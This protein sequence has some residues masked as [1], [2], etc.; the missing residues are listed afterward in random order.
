M[1][2]A[3]ALRLSAGAEGRIVRSA[4]PEDFEMPLDGFSTWITPTER[5]FVRSHFYRPEL[6]LE[7]W[8]LKAGKLA[9]DMAALRQFPRAELVGVLECAG[10]GRGLFKPGMPGVPWRYGAVG[11]ARWTGVRMAD[12]LRRAGFPSSV[13]HIL[14][15]GADEGIGSAPDFA[16][17]IP[18]EKAMHADTLLAYE[19]NGAPLPPEHGFPLRVVAPG[20]AG[21]SWVKWLVEIRGL[22]AEYD[23][24]FMKTAY[25]RPVK[26]VAPGTA[27][28]PA[29]MEPVTELGVKSVIASP[30]EGASVGPGQVTIRGAAWSGEAPVAR[31]EVSTDGGRTWTAAELSPD[32]APYAWRL[33]QASWTPPAK[34][35][36]ALMARATDTRGRTQPMEPAW[37]PSGYLFNAVHR[38]N[39]EAAAPFPESVKNS[40]VGCHGEDIIAGQRLTRAQW[41]REVEKM[42][43]WGAPVAP[44]DKAAIIQFLSENYKP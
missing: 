35:P 11:N 44:E 32:Q 29:E 42:A 13:K 6:K 23:G 3:P 25:R 30:V 40:C 24:F 8:R 33:W 5:F 26:P 7:E 37:N 27:V 22:E 19:M 2:A 17:S 16:R 18:I 38:V 12:V 34:G 14:C 39:V 36:H 31:V 1:A 4:N 21:D 9:L 15:D 10:N 43:S 41:E 28:N 20:W